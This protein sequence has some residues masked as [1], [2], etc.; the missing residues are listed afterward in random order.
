M[1][2]GCSSSRPRPCCRLLDFGIAPTV[3]RFTAY[4]R[5][6][7]DEERINAIASAGLAVYLMLGAASVAV[8]LVIAWFIPDLINLSP[9]LVRPAQVATRDS[10]PDARHPGAARTL[11]QPAQGLPAVRHP[12]HLRARLDPRVRGARRWRCSPQY[13][14]L[15]VLATIALVSTLI[16]LALPVYLRPPRDFRRCGSPAP[17]CVAASCASCSATRGSPS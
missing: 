2:R 10:R 9:D 11:W 8:G 17:T 14:S 16:R 4:H 12:Q 3:V 6:R 1:G 15:P 13:A 5:G 7:R